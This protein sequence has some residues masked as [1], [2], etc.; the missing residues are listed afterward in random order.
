[1]PRGVPKE[2][3]QLGQVY[4]IDYGDGT[5]EWFLC[6]DDDPRWPKEPH[7]LCIKSTYQDSGRAKTQRVGEIYSI[8]RNEDPIPDDEVPDEA[9][10]EVAKWRLLR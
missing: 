9:W 5:A 3:G 8:G 10:A 1:M 7:L 4:F 2:N 6:T